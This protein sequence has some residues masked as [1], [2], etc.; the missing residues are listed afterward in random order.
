M[1]PD[2]SEF[3]FGYALTNELVARFH[4]GSVGA[5]V[6]PSL[7]EEG[8]VG[9][10]VALP[11]IPVFLQFKLSDPMV[12]GTALEASRLG[13]PYYRMHLRPRRHSNQHELLL[14]LEAAGNEV[15]Y[16][17][18]EFHTPADLNLAYDSGTVVD[19]AAFW[20]PRDIGSL[21]DD[22]DHYI[23]FQVRGTVGYFCSEPREI[24]R[25]P[26]LPLLENHLPIQA[27]EHGQRSSPEYWRRLAALLLSTYRNLQWLA[28]VG[29]ASRR[30]QDPR[31]Q[32]AF[33]AQSLY[34][35]ALLWSTAE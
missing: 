1:R 20:R 3:S 26:A 21:V 32:A 15:Y 5:P 33:L 18:P 34:G 23:A 27:R 14:R 4:L 28:P 16:V 19:R 17:A 24:P 8:E 35:C 6:F 7:V 10:D 13:L 12:R 22:A 30:L 29:Q 31:D 11:G 25:T 9:Y 2:I